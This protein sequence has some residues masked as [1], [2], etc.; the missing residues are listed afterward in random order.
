MQ[1][2]VAITQTACC[3]DRAVCVCE[4]SN[5]VMASADY[6][7]RKASCDGHH[8]ALGSVRLCNS[9]LQPH[10]TNMGAPLH[11]D[12]HVAMGQPNRVTDKQVSHA[13]TLHMEYRQGQEHK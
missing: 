11:W 10:Y 9:M 12:K 2:D 4:A 3:V 6:D 7:M 8:R 1:I 13:C 5:A